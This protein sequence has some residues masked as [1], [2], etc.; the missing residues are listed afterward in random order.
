MP[1]GLQEVEASRISSQ[2]ELESGK[3]V[4][5][6][7]RL[8]LPQSHGGLSQRNIP[9]TPSTAKPA[10]FRLVT[11]CLKQLLY[12]VPPIY[13]YIKDEFNNTCHFAQWFNI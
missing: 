6:T 11:H 1:W 7:H 12:R 5:S 13:M 9:I 4:N 2:S 10:T 8:I 3:F